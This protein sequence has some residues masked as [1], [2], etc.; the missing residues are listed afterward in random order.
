MDKNI[1]AKELLK[2]AALLTGA[3]KYSKM[4]YIFPIGHSFILKMTI[5][6]NLDGPL[7]DH[8]DIK[9]RSDVIFDMLK[10]DAAQVKHKGYGE[11]DTRYSAA[12]QHKYKGGYVLGAQASIEVSLMAEEQKEIMKFVKTLGYKKA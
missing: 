5:V 11:K 1:V 7:D 12:Q 3:E 4:A 2:V 8:A 6:E 9:K 10:K